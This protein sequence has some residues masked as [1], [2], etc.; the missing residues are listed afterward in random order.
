VAEEKRVTG[1]SFESFAD[2]ARK[3]FDQIEGDPERE[4][5]A[6]AEVTGLWLEKGGV[7]GGVQYR[8]ELTSPPGR[9]YE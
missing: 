7:V 2:A 5:L 9:G 4:G 6:E 3:A 1:T 8:V